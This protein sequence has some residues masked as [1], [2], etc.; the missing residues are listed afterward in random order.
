VAVIL[1]SYFANPECL[2]V[3]AAAYLLLLLPSCSTGKLEVVPT[4]L[5]CW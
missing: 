1:L 5:M 2:F 3:A 4:K